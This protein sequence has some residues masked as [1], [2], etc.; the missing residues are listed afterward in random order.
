MIPKGLTPR[1]AE[2]GKIK[3][4][5]KSDHVRRTKSGGE[6]RAPE[7]YD[8]FV[9]TTPERNQGNQLIPDERLMESLIQEHGDH[10]GKLRQIPIYLLSDNIDE[11]LLARYSNTKGG[12]GLPTW[13]SWVTLP[14]QKPLQRHL[15]SGRHFD[16]GGR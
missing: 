14:G 4:G 6:W 15:Q 3:I 10:D 7:K 5:G 8:H 13:P 12:S 11:V 9:I 16:E 1:I 2:L